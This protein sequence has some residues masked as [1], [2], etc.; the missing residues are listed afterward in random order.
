MI[1]NQFEVV[2]SSFG[3]VIRCQASPLQ[4]QHHSNRHNTCL[5]TLPIYNFYCGAPVWLRVLPFE[6]S[7]GDGIQV[8]LRDGFFSTPFTL[9]YMTT[10]TLS[11]K[12]S[13]TSSSTPDVV[14]DPILYNDAIEAGQSLLAQGNTK[15]AAARAI[16]IALSK[17][18]RS[19]V[20]KAFVEGASITVKGAPTYFYNISRQL[21]KTTK[22]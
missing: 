7:L 17:S 2:I 12:V 20:L 8:P 9:T 1:A 15:A 11:D 3:P 21:K 18:P 22:R 4:H 19:V 16:F 13:E 5:Q 10:T 14:V 6:W